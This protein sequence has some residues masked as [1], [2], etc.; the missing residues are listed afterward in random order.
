MRRRSLVA[1]GVVAAFLASAMVSLDVRSRAR[2]QPRSNPT[3]L[4]VMVTAYC[5]DGKTKAGP[6]VRRGFVAADP[7]WLPLGSRIRIEGLGR[8]YGRTYTVM[9]TGPAVKGR[10]IDLYVPNCAA[11]K[12]FGR[13]PARVVVMRRGWGP[14]GPPAN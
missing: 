7:R 9:D 6:R 13:Q 4:K 14:A 10:E 11:A 1:G 3:V 8:R 12:R 5:V 2:Q